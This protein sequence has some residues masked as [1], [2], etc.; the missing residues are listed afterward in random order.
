ME[1]VLK[2]VPATAQALDALEAAGAVRLLRPERD[3]LPVERGDARWTE[4]YAA[5]DR[6]GP[7]KLIAVTINRT[8]PVSLS[9]HSDAEDFLLMPHGGEAELVLT[10]C[11]L[12]GE[13]LA[14]KVEAGTLSEDD[15]V[16]LRCRPEDP[17]VSFFT[18]NPGFPHVETCTRETET[19]PCFYVTESRHL[20]ENRADFGPYRIRI[21]TEPEPA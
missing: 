13:A 3:R 2:P 8:Q 14:R 17:A 18:M 20:D 10:V 6:F 4:L 16:A 7:H 1:I 15:F 21:E 19:P 9:W 5:A 11:L 12:R